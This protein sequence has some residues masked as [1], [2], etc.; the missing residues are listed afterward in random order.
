MLCH[1]FWSA[2]EQL[3]ADLGIGSINCPRAQFQNAGAPD[4]DW[5]NPKWPKM[6]Y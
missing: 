6:L 3:I 5:G 1:L 4:F 2:D